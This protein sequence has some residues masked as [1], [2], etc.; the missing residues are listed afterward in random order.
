MIYWY[1]SQIVQSVFTH[2]CPQSMLNNSQFGKRSLPTGI[3]DGQCKVHPQCC[4][5][6]WE[7][8]MEITFS[9]QWKKVPLWFHVDVAG[10][11]AWLVGGFVAAL[12]ICKV[13]CVP[14]LTWGPLLARP[15]AAALKAHFLNP[16]M[17]W[18]PKKRRTLGASITCY[19]ILVNWFS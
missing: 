6:I 19:I 5:N 4:V 18:A 10:A 8:T 1:Q 17:L 15:G 9:Y 11:A 3:T 13:M 14:H 7:N 16:S 2:W 12:H